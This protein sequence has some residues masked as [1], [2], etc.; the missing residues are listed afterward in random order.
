METSDILGYQKKIIREIQGRVM[1]PLYK[2][3]CRTS[4][5]ELYVAGEVARWD[6][7]GHPSQE[8]VE[9]QQEQG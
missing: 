7:S 4:V 2:L 1:S 5:P 3:S 8:N 9:V 6:G